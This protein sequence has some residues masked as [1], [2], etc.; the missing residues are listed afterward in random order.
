MD[1]LDRA[2]RPMSNEE[3]YAGGLLLRALDPTL[4]PP[5]IRDWL[6]REFGRLVELVGEGRR[7]ADFGCGTGRHLAALAPRLALGVGLDYERSYLAVAASRRVIGPVHFVLADA[8]RAPL[9]PRFDLAI[10]TTNT[11]GTMPY[12][13][14]VLREMRR[15]APHRGRRVISVF[16]PASVEVRRVW[17]ARLGHPVTAAAPEYLETADGFRSEH[18]TPDRLRALLGPCEIEPVGE[19]GLLALT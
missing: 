4:Q 8:S 7:V 14:G 10:C 11:W 13:D 18:F 3:I 17:Y 19:V 2:P 5:P 9:P 6:E 1:H 12:K 15:V 16:G